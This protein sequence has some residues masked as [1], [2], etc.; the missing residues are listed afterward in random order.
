MLP[1][2][3]RSLPS[4]RSPRS[5]IYVRSLSAKLKKYITGGG[6]PNLGPDYTEVLRE[7][8]IDGGLVYSF[9]ILYRDSSVAVP[10]PCR[11]TTSSGVCC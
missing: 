2:L 3:R 9:A 4:A 8:D 1:L 7:K 10:S 11:D 5:S 6:L